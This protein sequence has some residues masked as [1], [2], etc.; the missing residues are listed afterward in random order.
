MSVCPFRR[1]VVKPKKTQ[2][3]E[4]T[5]QKKE[6]SD[7]RESRDKGPKPGMEIANGTRNGDK[8]LMKATHFLPTCT[9]CSAGLGPICI[10]PPFQS[11]GLSVL[12]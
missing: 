11:H 2:S 9:P 6:E 12:Q 10:L 3:E 5:K 7:V 1:K 4:N 8:Q